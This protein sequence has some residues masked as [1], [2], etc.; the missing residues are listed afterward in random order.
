MVQQT[1]GGAIPAFL[2]RNHRPITFTRS[3]H[4][5]KLVGLLNQLYQPAPEILRLHGLR[6]HGPT[7]KMVAHPAYIEPAR[8]IASETTR[9]PNFA[10]NSKTIETPIILVASATALITESPAEIPLLSKT[11]FGEFI[12]ALDD[13]IKSLTW[14]HSGRPSKSTKLPKDTENT[15]DGSEEVL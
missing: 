7:D 12:A 13:A 15:M 10:K 8:A 9:Y 4:N 11:T 3:V 1:R 6:L 2:T 5:V 14:I